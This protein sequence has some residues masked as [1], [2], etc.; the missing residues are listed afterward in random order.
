MGEVS[1]GRWSECAKNL[2]SYFVSYCF[3]F[4]AS[5]YCDIRKQE[6]ISHMNN[7]KF[8]LPNMFSKCLTLHKE[9]M[10][11]FFCKGVHISVAIRLAIEI[12]ASYST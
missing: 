11:F 10:W 9:E 6:A 7:G 5:V 1:L 12:T 8:C 2:I 3:K 4:V